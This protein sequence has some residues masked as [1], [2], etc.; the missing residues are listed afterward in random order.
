MW[1]DVSSEQLSKVYNSL[2]SY[3]DSSI[4]S[5]KD[6]TLFSDTHKEC[7]IRFLNGIVKITED[8]IEFINNE[9][10]SNKNQVWEINPN[11]CDVILAS[12]SGGPVAFMPGFKSSIVA[13]TATS[14]AVEK[15][16]VGR[17]ATQKPNCY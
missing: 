17:G 14:V 12:G 9:D 13:N 8:D 16:W 3:G 6:L 11:T 2:S 15:I 1:V 4:E 10:F 5:D 7:Y